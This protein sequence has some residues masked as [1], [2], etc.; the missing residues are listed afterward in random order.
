[1]QLKSQFSNFGL[2]VKIHFGA[3]DLALG[4]RPNIYSCTKDQ[5]HTSKT[6]RFLKEVRAE[7]W[8]LL[9]P[10]II[11]KIWTVKNIRCPDFEWSV[12]A[13]LLE[14]SI[15]NPTPGLPRCLLIKRLLFFLRVNKG[16]LKLAVV[17][18]GSNL[19]CFKFK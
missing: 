3:L 16:A 12:W 17:A 11:T 9:L 8:M 4:P 14:I 7:L 10:R 18:Q 13:S 6:L 5:S 2:M 19:P 1:M 15:F